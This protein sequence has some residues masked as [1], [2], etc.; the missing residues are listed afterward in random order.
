MTIGLL[1]WCV[2][3][4]AAAAS[5]L[6]YE[7]RVARAAEQIKRIQKDDNYAEEGVDYVKK[8]LPK[9]EP[10]ELQGRVINV[11]NEWLHQHLDLAVAEKQKAARDLLLTEVR[12]WLEALDHHLQDAEDI[13]RA[14][15]NKAAMQERLK[16]ILAQEQYRDKKEN[17]LA[18][19]IK[20]LRKAVLDL[21][22]RIW[23]RIMTALFGAGNAGSGLFK[24]IFF[25][26]AAI[27]AYFII[28]MIWKYKPTKKKAK[29]KTV[30]G[31]EIEEDASP[32][33]LA[34][35]AMAAAKAGDFRLG[36][37]KLYIAFLYEMSERNLIELHTHAT[38]RE[39]LSMVAKFSSLLPAMS[40]MT[41][42]FDYFWYGMFPSSQE[43]F[44]LYL[45]RYQAAVR[46]MQNI[47]TQTL[48]AG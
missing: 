29:K 28:H 34:E 16:N 48:Q 7:K 32:S 11:D 12:G 47:N 6:D 26:V 25:V 4:A 35:A 27:V 19:K 44:S 3:I 30:L 39:Y 24:F 2:G 10:V 33:D 43:D 41:D 40:Y 9:T 13:S 23:T 15:A 17:P 20:K 31:E 37:R 45:E 14:D 1:L 42:R 18:A 22:T 5:L 8:L 46:H 36:V 21:I 38:N